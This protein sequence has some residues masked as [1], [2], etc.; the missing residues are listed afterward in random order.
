M[1]NLSLAI[2]ALSAALLMRGANAAD[3]RKASVSDLESRISAGDAGAMVQLATRYTSGT[4]VPVDNNK[5]SALLRRAAAAGSDLA[6]GYCAR[7]GKG[8]PRDTDLAFRL[9]AKA[10]EQREPLGLCYLAECYISGSGTKRNLPK[11]ISLL[12]KAA[13]SG[14]PEAILEL[15]RAHFVGV[16]T[17]RSEATALAVLLQA[18]DSGSSSIHGQIAYHY[19]HGYGCDRDDAQAE[20]YALLALK[21]GIRSTYDSLLDSYRQA[22]DF[23]RANQL[24][25]R[26]G[27]QGDPDSWIKLAENF[28]RGRGVAGDPTKAH[29]C[30][31]KAGE[32]GDGNGYYQ[33]ALDYQSGRGVEASEDLYK[34]LLAKAADMGNRDARALITRQ[35]PPAPVEG[36]FVPLNAGLRVPSSNASPAERFIHQLTRI[37][38]RYLLDTA[39][40]PSTGSTLDDLTWAEW[41]A[42][43]VVALLQSP[44]GKAAPPDLRA[45]CKRSL[46]L[47]AAFLLA[48]KT[49]SPPDLGKGGGPSLAQLGLGAILAITGDMEAEAGR[50]TQPWLSNNT[51]TNRN[52]QAFTATIANDMILPAMRRV[53]KSN[54]LLKL[55]RAKQQRD[56]L[57]TRWAELLSTLA[58][59]DSSLQPYAA[60][61][62]TSDPSWHFAA[63]HD[64]GEIFFGQCVTTRGEGEQSELRRNAPSVDFGN[65]ADGPILVHIRSSGKG[66][67]FQFGLNEKPRDERRYILTCTRG[68]IGAK[69]GIFEG[70]WAAR[71]M[72]SWGNNGQTTFSINM[73]MSQL[74]A[75]LPVTGRASE[76]EVE[77]SLLI[78]LPEQFATAEA[79]IAK[80][81][82]VNLFD[83]PQ[84]SS[85]AVASPR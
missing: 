67:A 29:E 6:K 84:M 12:E 35:G 56:D 4:G 30:F 41:R 13:E 39:Y 40:R 10:A 55:A 20:T 72:S 58:A 43:S 77:G 1:G 69:I 79:A 61:P 44:I 32:L 63:L 19:L 85:K 52:L 22:A 16:G 74:L 11:A 60:D 34:A 27:Q 45:F 70:L 31:L 49:R 81:R 76:S 80:A 21:G 64:L 14:E 68:H 9:F 25:L 53:E 33:A 57:H 23:A 54:Q 3:L 75:H 38:T 8:Q 15:S 71:G 51:P 83:L 78:Y 36:E 37:S 47:D 26:A 59:S 42:N 46:E 7:F 65:P 17:P 82:H 62:R 2:I 73:R 66:W 48:W 5:H 24:Y 18:K 28:A 50:S